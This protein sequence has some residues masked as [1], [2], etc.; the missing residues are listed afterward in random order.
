M[1]L[2]TLIAGH[3]FYFRIS[4]R[5]VAVGT[6]RITRPVTVARNAAA[7]ALAARVNAAPSAMHVDLLAWE[8]LQTTLNA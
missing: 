8:A 3:E 1:S 7:T 2:D 6:T 5:K 4:P